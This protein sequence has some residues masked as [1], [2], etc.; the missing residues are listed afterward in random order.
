MTSKQ[1]E[2]LFNHLNTFFGHIYILTIERAKERQ[3]AITAE[4]HGLRFSFFY[5]FDKNNLQLETLEQ[6]NTYSNKNA[7]KNSRYSKPMK[8]GEIACSMGHKAIYE[9]MILNNYHTALILE[10]DVFIQTKDS[11]VFLDIVNQLPKNWDLIYFDYLKNDTTSFKDY[12]KQLVYHVQR[13]LGLLKWSHTTINNLF[14]KPFSN[15]LKIAGYHD[16]ASAYAINKKTAQLLVKLQTPISYPAD[17]V[18]PFVVTNKMIN[19]FITIPKIFNQFSQN[20]KENY[21]SYVEQ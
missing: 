4:L 9:D 21:G 19:A 12:F 15:N 2:E 6:N 1:R 16:F 20:N 18:L 10:D 17:H 11:T 3:Q 8:L 5:G 14:A 13:N 7:I